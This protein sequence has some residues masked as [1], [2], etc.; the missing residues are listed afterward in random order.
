MPDTDLSIPLNGDTL[1]RL[2][3][4]GREEGETR[5]AAVARL[6]EEGLR[7]ARHRGVVFRPGPA[8]RR[9]SL[10]DGPDVW[11]VAYIFRDEALDTDQSRLDAIFD[12]CAAMSLDYIQA[13]AAVHYYIEYRDEIDEW[14]R[15]NDEEAERGYAEWLAK[16]Q[17]V[18]E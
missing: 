7:M 4:H 13:E 6:L 12:T 8:G 5:E 11:Q 15:S 10:F 1:A 16:Q 9:A 18:G 3:A 14:M 17:T 2:D